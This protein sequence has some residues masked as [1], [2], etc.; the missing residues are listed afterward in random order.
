M[1]N[2]IWKDIEGYEGLYQV[3]NKGRVRSLDHTT[4]HKNRHGTFNLSQ[5]SGGIKAQRLFKCGYMYV[6]LNKEGTPRTFRVHRLVAQAFILNPENLPHIN[7]KNEDRTDNRAENLEWCDSKYNNNYGNRSRKLAV[8]KCKGKKVAHIDEQG[9]IL[10]IY[11]S[12]RAAQDALGID[13]N[14]ISFVACGFGKHVKGMRFI[15]V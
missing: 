15:Y 9:K 1:E 12:P 8:T 5:Y 4:F 13:R 10:A 2:E 14:R 6:I 11:S 7:H 3:S